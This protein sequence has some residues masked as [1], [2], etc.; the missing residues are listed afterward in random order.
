MKQPIPTN[1]EKTFSENELIISKSD[2][3]NNIICHPEMPKIVFKL[4]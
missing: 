4:L 2:V 1:R 3:Y